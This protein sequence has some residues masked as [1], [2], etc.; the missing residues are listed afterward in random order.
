MVGNDNIIILLDAPSWP[1][2]PGDTAR[3]RVQEKCTRPG[4]R[5]YICFPG[6]NV[7]HGVHNVYYVLCTLSSDSA[8]F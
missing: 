4:G 6:G 5:I 3:S 2:F 8:L 7:P 1:A